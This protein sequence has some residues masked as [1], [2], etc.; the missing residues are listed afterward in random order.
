MDGTVTIGVELETKSFEQ[1]I[2][3]TENYL[4]RLINS[5]EKASKASGNFKPNEEAMHNLRVE[6]EKTNNKLIDLRKRQEKTIE[7]G[8]LGLNKVLKK[9]TKWG[10]AIFG[11]R[12]AYMAIRQAMN[13]ITSNDEQLKADIDYMKTAIAYSLEPL[14]RQ[15]VEWAKTLLQYIGYIIKAWTG[16]NIF[17][18]ANKSLKKANKNAKEL[19]K[20]LASFDEI[21]ILGDKGNGTSTLM[22]SFDLSN[23]E[24]IDAPKWLKWIAE[25]KDVI[26]KI[27]E[28][29]LVAFGISNIRKVLSNIALLFGSSGGMGLIGLSEILAIIGTAYLVTIA[30]KGVKEVIDKANEVKDSMNNLYEVMDSTR[31][32]SKELVDTVVS[33][34][35]N[36]TDNQKKQFLI[37][38]NDQIQIARNQIELLSEQKKKLWWS[39]S[40]QKEIENQ[41]DAYKR[42]IQELTKTKYEIQIKTG[43]DVSP[44]AKFLNSVVSAG[45]NKT[46]STTYITLL[47][48]KFTLTGIPFAK[49]GV[50]VPKLARGAIAN[51]PGRGVPTFDGGAI[52]AERGAEAYLPLTDSQQMDL[53]GSSIA[54]HM[55]VNLTNINQL[56]GRVI[57]REL[58]KINAENDFAYNQ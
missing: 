12:S 49:G 8:S 37:Y 50:V 17:E 54:K 9:I 31:K 3:K 22:P 15:I 13:I 25:N 56:N 18:N 24:N 28:V 53:L 27:G 43:I 23:I 42:K 55:V 32:K 4:N 10:L 30:I 47:G 2:K 14:V 29:L 11:V 41:I 7:S 45:K 36:L 19:K 5:Y 46:S 1:E 38:L 40:Q 35:D 48:K 44:L 21:N 58:N 57:S 26:L 39:S 51:N 16:Y 52:W 6:I 20:T 34:Y 33:N